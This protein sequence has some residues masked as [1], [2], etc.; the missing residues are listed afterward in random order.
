MAENTE[1]NFKMH[2]NERINFLS[3]SAD[4]YDAGYGGEAKRMAMVIHSLIQDTGK[5]ASSLTLLKKKDISFYDTANKDH[6]HN[7]APT[8][9]LA[10]MQVG[11]KG[12]NYIPLLGEDIEENRRVPFQK[13][14]DKVVI[15]YSRGNKLTRKDLILNAAHK[16]LGLHVD[17][18][19]NE[20][21][22]NLINRVSIRKYSTDQ[23]IDMYGAELASVRQIAYEVLKSLKDEFPEYF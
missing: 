19:L 20:D 1:E 16:D 3:R 8:I 5:S 2:L 11:P 22:A 6:P 15:A 17:P 4:S 10:I 12:A 18:K 9:A 21:Y 7:P 13:W 14:W 23:E